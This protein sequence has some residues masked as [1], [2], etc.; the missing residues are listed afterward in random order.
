[1]AGYIR[2]TGDELVIDGSPGVEG[3]A[4]ALSDAEPY[5]RAVIEAWSDAIDLGST[6]GLAWG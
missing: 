1:V 3:V 4:V 6:F 2:R 5:L